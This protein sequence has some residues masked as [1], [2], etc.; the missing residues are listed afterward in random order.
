MSIKITLHSCCMAAAVLAL[1][2]SG[3][4]AATSCVTRT[5]GTG[6]YTTTI[7]VASNFTTPA[8]DMVDA[9]QLTDDGADT[10]I[11]ICND[12]T[13]NLRSQIDANSNLYS[14][15]FAADTTANYYDTT[16]P[17]IAYS[18]AKGVPVYFT[19]RGTSRTV[20]NLISN[21]AASDKHS[22]YYATLTGSDLSAYT[23]ADTTT[24]GST[25]IANAGAPYGVKAHAIVNSIEALT[26]TNAMPTTIPTW[27]VSPLYTNINLTF[28]AVT[29]SGTTK[30]GFV[31]LAQ[32]C[33]IK[34]SVA[35]VE[36]TNT[37]YVLDQKA[38]LLLPSDT[39]AANLNSYIQGQ[40]SA[41]T[42]NSTFL[43][44]HCYG[45]I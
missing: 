44:L 42:W 43:P 18:Y 30:N 10:A 40:M 29:T 26:G 25:A 12:S 37:N 45:T 33:N 32:I 6:E 35:Y 2:A 22:S 23:I 15:L 31:S 5:V 4:W 3:G 8:Q 28:D 14:M 17:R 19:Y 20:D 39:V 7:A 27:V 21:L 1:T 41:G 24:A 36:F 13:T 38:I 34:S 16:S 11:T 9:F